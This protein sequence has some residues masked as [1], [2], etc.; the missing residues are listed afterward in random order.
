MVL[1]NTRLLTLSPSA[2]SLASNTLPQRG[3]R[4]QSTACWCSRFREREH[5]RAPGA[6]A[7]AQYCPSK[8]EHE[9]HSARVCR[10]ILI[11]AVRA[12]ARWL[13][14]LTGQV[15]PKACLSRGNLAQA[16]GKAPVFLI[17]NP[18][19]AHRLKCREGSTSSAAGASCF[20]PQPSWPISDLRALA[21]SRAVLL[22]FSPSYVPYRCAGAPSPSVRSA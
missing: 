12:S 6:R 11:T 17:S 20:F 14:A 18:F 1:P 22:E 5:A 9:E 16:E 3:V 4:P 7:H 15:I 10:V 21:T 13:F 8:Q 2:T 19:P